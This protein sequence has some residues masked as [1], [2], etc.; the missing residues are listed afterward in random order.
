MFYLLDSE[1]PR[2]TYCPNDMLES[3]DTPSQTTKTVQW[4]KPTYSDNSGIVKLTFNNKNNP[5]DFPVGPA[6]NIIYRIE[7]GSDNKAECEFSIK[8]EGNRVCNIMYPLF[9]HFNCGFVKTNS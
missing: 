8:V 6:I 7:D 3:A 4:T 2:F 5:S 1:K 9:L